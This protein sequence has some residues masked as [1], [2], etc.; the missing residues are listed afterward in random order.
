MSAQPPKKSVFILEG[1]ELAAAEIGLPMPYSQLAE[2]SS[3]SDSK[4]K[5]AFGLQMNG[6]CFYVFFEAKDGSEKT[7]VYSVRMEQVVNQIV[8]KLVEAREADA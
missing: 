6:Q 7:K 5:I 4:Y 8:N 1:I 3:D 2:L